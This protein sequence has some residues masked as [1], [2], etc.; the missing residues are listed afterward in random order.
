MP[1][2]EGIRTGRAIKV[3]LVEGGKGLSPFGEVTIMG[4][5]NNGGGR[6]MAPWAYVPVNP[7]YWNIVP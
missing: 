5:E 1:G 6:I 4:E 7:E 2:G 3:Y